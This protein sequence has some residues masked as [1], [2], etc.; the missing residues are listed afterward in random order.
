MAE[1]STFLLSRCF[2]QLTGRKVTFVQAP[3]GLPSK[4]EQAYGIYHVVPQ[5]VPVIVKADL[6]L[7]GS[8][9]GALVGLPDTAV[10]EHLRANPMEEL[11]RDAI[12]EVLNIA[13]AAVSAEGRTVFVKMVRDPAFIEG[14]AGKTFKE[15]FHR[16]FF[17]VTIDGYQGGKFAILSAFVPIKVETR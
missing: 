10:K 3:A 16:S 1:P 14:V 15:P 4:V 6:Q 8:I 12:C 17:T 11:M 9:A 5:E 7:L 2:S 13:A